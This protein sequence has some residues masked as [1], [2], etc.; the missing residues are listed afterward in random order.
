MYCRISKIL[1]SIGLL[2]LLFSCS[3]NASDDTEPPKISNLE[4]GYRPMG[5]HLDTL[6]INSDS[7]YFKVHLSDNVGLS[8]YLVKIYST[9]EPTST[10]SMYLSY[11]GIWSNAT[12]FGKTD[13]DILKNLKLDYVQTDTA[14]S[15]TKP[16]IPGDYKFMIVSLDLAGN[17]DTIYKDIMLVYPDTTS[18]K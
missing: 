11:K 9:K 17:A 14:S 8:T 15:V 12:S 4:V 18:I 10:D 16:V 6:W 13:I 7:S 3:D 5:Q 2:S 1:L